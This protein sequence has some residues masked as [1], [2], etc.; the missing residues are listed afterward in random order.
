[1]LLKVFIFQNSYFLSLVGEDTLDTTPRGICSLL[2]KVAP[3]DAL[4]LVSALVS[5]NPE[6][7][8]TAAGVLRSRFLEGTKASSAAPEVVQR[9]RDLMRTCQRS[10]PPQPQD[11][12]FGA[13]PLAKPRI[14][15][16][17]AILGRV[18]VI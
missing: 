11:E 4:T 3:D 9:Q 2:S 17:R 14:V 13:S 8:P 18:N 7:R 12:N 1:M 16:P 10:K 6:H 5:L 15:D